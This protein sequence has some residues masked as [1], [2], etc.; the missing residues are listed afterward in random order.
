MSGSIFISYRRS[1]ASGHA[2]WLHDRLTQWFDA[3]ESFFD[4]DES[5][6]DVEHTYAG[7]LIPQ[8]LADGIDTAK[9]VLTLIDPDWLRKINRR[10]AFADTDFVQGEVERALQRQDGPDGPKF[11]PVLMGIAARPSAAELHDSLLADV[12][13]LLPLD[14]H[15]FQGKNANWNQ[16]F[17]RLRELIAAVPGV[18]VPRYRAPV[19][20]VQPFR[21]IEKSLN[22][23]SSD[24]NDILAALQRTFEASGAAAVVSHAAIYGMGGV[25][26]TQ[27][28]LKYGLKFRDRYAGVWWYR[29]ETDTTLQLNALDCCQIVGAAVGEGE[30]PSLAL[31]RWL[32]QTGAGAPPWLL[33][34]NNAEDPAVLSPNLPERGDHHVLITLRDPAWSGIARLV[35]TAVW[36][37]EQST[38]FLARRLSVHASSHD[39]AAL[40]ELAEALG[41]LPL[42][43]E[44]AAGFLDKTDMAA[45]EYTA[46]VRGYESALLVLNERRAATGYERSVLATLSIAFPHLS[47]A[48]AQLMRLP[49]F[50]APDPVPERLFREQPEHLPKA[51][52]EAVR[53]PLRWEKAVTGLRRY[54]LAERTQIKARHRVPGQPNERKEQVLH[55]HRLTQQAARQ[56]MSAVAQAD[57]GELLTLQYHAL[58]MDAELP[59]HWPRYKSL[60]PHVLQFD[61]LSAHVSIDRRELAWLLDSSAS[62]FQYGPALYAAARHGFERALAR[63][64]D[65]WGEEHPNTPTSMSNI[66]ITLWHCEKRRYAVELLTR[67][68]VACTSK[69][70]GHHP[71]TFERVN[72]LAQMRAAFDAF[73]SPCFNTP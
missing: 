48:A 58:P 9:V 70:G 43:L 71:D 26:K 50:C 33:V 35:T 62:Y 63:N 28:A 57:A 10:A 32:G 67:T 45:A 1:D 14:V 11:I 13:P 22:P 52:A 66:A 40:R 34:F 54:G 38:D 12:A 69:L 55:L 27:V 30:S 24:P 20:T 19:D 73:T 53:Q 61:R 16:Q 5:F 25:G 29:A 60:V 46:Q 23:H 68:G 4:A 59:L 3:D 56:R 42:A 31:K 64:C 6:F 49:E 36:T 2:G 39:P 37:P 65:D 21:V 7:D 47:E 51:L 18:P 72:I 44:Q 8:R 41:G 15:T 17:V